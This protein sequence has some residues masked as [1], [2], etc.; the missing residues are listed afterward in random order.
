MIVS[1]TTPSKSTAMIIIICN[2]KMYLVNA[3]SN[4]SLFAQYS[5][6]HW[7]CPSNSLKSLFSHSPH[8]R[9]SGKVSLTHLICPLSNS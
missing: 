4:S 9:I 1:D 7:T 8:Q 2:S 3:L 5:L 6:I